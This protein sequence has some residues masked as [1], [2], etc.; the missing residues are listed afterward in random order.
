MQKAV[1]RFWDW[2]YHYPKGKSTLYRYPSP[3]SI[4]KQQPIE[5]YKTPFEHTHLNVRYSKPL[6]SVIN[7][8]PYVIAGD[9]P[10]VSVVDK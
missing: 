5:D 10:G 9:G 7:G 6:K 1:N 3:G 2:L 8:D 4:I